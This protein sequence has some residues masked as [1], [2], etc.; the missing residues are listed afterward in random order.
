MEHVNIAARIPKSLWK[1]AKIRAF[2]QGITLSDWVTEALNEYLARNSG[3]GYP[4]GNMAAGPGRVVEL[5]ARRGK[6]PR[7]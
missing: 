6:S 3:S 1:E 4:R 2:E 5:A 7:G